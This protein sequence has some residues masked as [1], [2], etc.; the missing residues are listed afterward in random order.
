[1]STAQPRSADRPHSN[2]GRLRRS[3][4]SMLRVGLLLLA[5]SLVVTLI[6]GLATRSMLGQLRSGSSELLDG[7]GSV[8]LD[9]GDTRSLYVTGG[10]VAPGE[11]LPTPVEEITCSVQGP[12][13]QVPVSHLRDQD[14]TVGIDNPLA[15][16]QVVGSFTATAAGDHQVD[17]TGLGVVVAPQVSPASALLRVGGLLLGSLGLFAGATLALIGSLLRLFTRHG[18]DEEEDDDYETD[19]E[20]PAEGADEW[21]EEENAT[22]D[23]PPAAR[24]DDYVT[25]TDDELAELSEAEIADLLRSG[26]LVYVDEDGKVVPPV[27]APTRTDDGDD[28]YR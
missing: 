10:L 1:M 15:R 13:G 28:T 7:T 17:C 20:P 22:A 4:R 25:L 27:D 2:R 5:V 18:T 16:F 9:A 23:E 12:S 3:G 24:E 6:A 19:A 8:T 14:R 11:E 21:W 26:A